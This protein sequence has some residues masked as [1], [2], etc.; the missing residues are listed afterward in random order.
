METVTSHPNCSLPFLLAILY[1]FDSFFLLCIMTFCLHL[2]RL[3]T[4]LEARDALM[5]VPIKQLLRFTKLPVYITQ[6]YMYMY[7]LLNASIK[8]ECCQ[9]IN[10]FP[11]IMLYG[12]TSWNFQQRN[13]PQR[14]PCRFYRSLTRFVPV[15][16]NKCLTQSV[17]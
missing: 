11:G 15:L 2:G 9:L 4:I 1:N 10:V 6:L 14:W 7:M 16:R 17:K 5:A 13:T 8:C 12:I 3:G